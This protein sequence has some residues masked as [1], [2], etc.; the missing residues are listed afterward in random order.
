MVAVQCFGY[1]LIVSTIVKNAIVTG[2]SIVKQNEVTR[3]NVSW[4]SCGTCAEPIV[5][6]GIVKINAARRQEIVWNMEDA[7]ILYSRNNGS[8]S[9]LCEGNFTGSIVTNDLEQWVTFLVGP[10]REYGVDI[11]ISS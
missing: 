11:K 9:F 6:F 3:S 4:K 2:F 8:V 7:G 10:R 1:K 5:G